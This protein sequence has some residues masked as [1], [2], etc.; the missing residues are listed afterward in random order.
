MLFMIIKPMLASSI[1]DFT[2]LKFP[3]LASPKLD[4]I[5]CLKI[6][7]NVVSRNLKR[8]PNNYIRLLIEQH[9]PNGFDGEIVC[10]NKTFNEIQS[11]VMSEEGEPEFIF[12]VF[13]YVKNDLKKEYINRLEDLHYFSKNNKFSFIKFLFPIKINNIKE[14][15]NFEEQQ[16]NLG[17][18][19]I[20]VRT[21]NSPYKCGRSTIKE[22]FLLKIK[23]FNDSEAKIIGFKE[24]KN[25]P[26]TLGSILVK[27]INTAI[28]FEIGTGFDDNLKFQIWNNKNNYYNKIITYSYQSSGM[29][30]KPRFP[31]FKGFRHINDIT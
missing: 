16:I 23:K 5:R 9:C 14:L 12:Q 2:Q 29:K 24:Q 30:N 22:C 27:D 6:N 7:N 21:T 13:D 19:G 25:N 10:P 20:M 17:F 1:K 4:G 18:E 26:N 28:E 8:I 11:L 31:S 15:V 3:I